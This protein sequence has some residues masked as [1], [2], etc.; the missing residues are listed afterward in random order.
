MGNIWE[1]LHVGLRLN[2]ALRP[3]LGPALVY[4]RFAVIVCH[5][6][7]IWAIV[8]QSR[9]PELGRG[10]TASAPIAPKLQGDCRDQAT[11]IGLFRVGCTAIRVE[12]IWIRECAVARPF[13]VTNTSGTQTIETKP[14]KVE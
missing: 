9:L 1:K 14:W 12:S 5:L 3:Y 8:S 7:T 13:R 10:V 4:W 11:I 6:A 2:M